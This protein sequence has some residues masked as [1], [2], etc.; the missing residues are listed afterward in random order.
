MIGHGGS[1]DVPD[2][3]DFLNGNTSMTYNTATYN[4]EDLKVNIRRACE[5]ITLLMIEKSFA[6]YQ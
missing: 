4:F 2:I 5:L 1:I 3:P 6:D